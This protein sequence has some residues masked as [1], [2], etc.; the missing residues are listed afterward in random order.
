MDPQTEFKGVTLVDLSDLE[1]LFEVNIMV[2]S[3]QPSA[4]NEEDEVPAEIVASLVRRSH[5]HYTS[6]LYLNL[7]KDHFSYIKSLPL[8]SKSHQCKKCGKLWKHAWKFHRHEQKCEAKVKLR[9]P[10]GTYNSPPTIFDQLTDEG[11]EIPERLKY[12]K[13]FATY[14]FE[15][16]FTQDQL[17]QNTEKLTWENKHVPLSVSC[18]SNIPGF[19]DPKCYITEG[20][21]VQLLKQFVDFLLAMS[22]ESYRLLLVDFEQVF[23]DIDAKMGRSSSEE[24]DP[25]IVG[26]VNI[27]MELLESQ[28]HE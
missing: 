2:Y 4:R 24:N 19:T 20:D 1:K 25:E 23:A 9:F 22:E 18:C 28:A 16:M 7:Y 14:D 27:L 3:L 21:S 12:F 15:F 8:Y 11:I 5:R 6:T 10:G 13:F 17:P 26:N